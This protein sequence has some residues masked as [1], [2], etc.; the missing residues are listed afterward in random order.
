MCKPPKDGESACGDGCVN[1]STYTECAKESIIFR[2]SNRT[3]LNQ[4]KSTLSSDILIFMLRIQL[5]KKNNLVELG[6]AVPLKI[7]GPDSAGEK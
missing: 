2:Y 5:N 6:S 4:I 7:T 1:R 3:L